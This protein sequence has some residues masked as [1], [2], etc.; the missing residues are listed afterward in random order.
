M[1]MKKPAPRWLAPLTDYGPLAVFFATYLLT[2]LMTATAALMAATVVALAISYGIARRVPVMAVVTAVIVGVFGGLTLALQDETF[3]KMK[4]TIVQLIFAAVLLAGLALGRT[5]L[6]AVMGKALDMDDDGWRKLSLRY[7]LFF[8]AMAA[9]NEVVW[10][11]Q[12]ES[13]W[14]SFKVFGLVALTVA[15][16]LA[17]MPLISRHQAAAQEGDDA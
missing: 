11:T 6:K 2:D 16:T 9:L 8:V 17:Q 7:A 4:P 5:P 14:V 3:I 13:F 1:T 15:F 10:R 12:S